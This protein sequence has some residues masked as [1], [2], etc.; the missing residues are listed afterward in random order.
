MNILVAHGSDPSKDSDTTGTEPSPSSVLEF[1]QDTQ[2]VLH[3]M[4]SEGD[5]EG[6]R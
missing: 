2:N 6:V 3:R 1:V 5:V 4:V